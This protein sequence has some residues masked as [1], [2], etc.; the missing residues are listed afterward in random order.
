MDKQSSVCLL[1][2]K[3]PQIVGVS[4]R[5]CSTANVASPENE[6]RNIV[7]ANS[8][9]RVSS[10]PSLSA[11]QPLASEP[12]LESKSFATLLRHHSPI[13]LDFGM[14]VR[15]SSRSG[16]SSSSEKLPGYFNIGPFNTIAPLA[17]LGRIRRIIPESGDLQIDFG[18]KFDAFVTRDRIRPRNFVYRVGDIVDIKINDV[19]L[20]ASFSSRESHFTLN[21]GHVTII[22]LN[23][24]SV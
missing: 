22:G 3:W 15:G 23:K 1:L 10:M 19:E 12:D 24:N 21:E 5:T 9:P 7:V 18:H 2:T 20:S 16:S 13:L 17:S 4:R 11:V 8:P 14:Q 6:P